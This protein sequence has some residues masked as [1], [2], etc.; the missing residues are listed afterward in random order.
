MN[1]DKIIEIVK[2]FPQEFNLEDLMEKLVFIK[3]VNKGLE[4][5]NEGR[6]LT[7]AQL[8]QCVTKLRF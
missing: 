3:K 4:Q 2:E 1:R 5:I 6:T 7:H 8:K